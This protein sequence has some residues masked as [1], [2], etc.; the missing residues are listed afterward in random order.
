MSQ[1]DLWAEAN[2]AKK[3]SFNQLHMSRHKNRFMRSDEAAAPRRRRSKRRAIR[4]RDPG[5]HRRTPCRS[6][7]FVWT[8]PLTRFSPASHL[9]LSARSIIETHDLFHEPLRRDS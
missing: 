1:S 7:P 6:E 5:V 3:G 9:S 4:S 2:E 8:E